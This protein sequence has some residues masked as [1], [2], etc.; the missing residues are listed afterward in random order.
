MFHTM[1][2]LSYIMVHCAIIVNKIFF[3]KLCQVFSK[4]SWY[5]PLFYQ[6][7]PSTSLSMLTLSAEANFFKVSVFDI[8]INSR[9]PLGLAGAETHL[10]NHRSLIWSGRVDSNHRLLAPQAS[11]LNQTGPRPGYSAFIG[12]N[13][14]SLTANIGDL[15]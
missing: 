8:G 15:P 11:A 9:V 12:R 4:I 14:N 7:P 3:A 2:Q 10:K 6:V 13:I 5:F 1:A